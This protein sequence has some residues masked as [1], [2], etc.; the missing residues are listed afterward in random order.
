MSPVGDGHF[1]HHRLHHDVVRLRARSVTALVDA[2]S[3]RPRARLLHFRNLFRKCP[4]LPTPTGG[5]CCGTFSTTDS[6]SRSPRP[7]ARRKRWTFCPQLFP[8]APHA[9][10]RDTGK[11][12]AIRCPSPPGAADV[13]E[14]VTL[15]TAGNGRRAPPCRAARLHC[16]LAAD[17]GDGRRAPPYR[18][19]EPR[20]DTA[21]KASFTAAVVTTA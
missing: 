8:P 18:R 6:D 10:G 16:H 13:F 11:L 4:P 21:L 2:R 12:R 5:T 7:R 1:A 9:H 3:P 20:R 15:L 17:G 19:R 14:P